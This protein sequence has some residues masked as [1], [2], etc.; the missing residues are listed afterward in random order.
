[1]DEARSCGFNP[2]TMH[3]FGRR[4]HERLEAAREEF[5]TLLGCESREISFT[6]GGT[7]SDNVAVLGFARANL[8]RR[9]LLILSA[10]EH[11]AC[12]QA[13]GRAAQEGAEVRLVAVDGSGTVRLDSLSE[14]LSDAG[15]RP[16][17]V[18]IMW[19][20]NEVGTV[21]PMVEIARL[22]HQ[23]DALLH[24]DAVQA[25]GKAEVSI[26]KLP[27][28]LLTATAHKLGGPVGIGLLYCRQGVDLEPLTFGGNQ[29]GGLW[30]GTQNPVAAVGFARAARLAVEGR[31]SATSRWLQ[32]RLALEGALRDG[33]PEL[34]VH[35]E[36]A[37]E[38]LPHLLSVGVPECDGGTL[39]LTLDLE[40]IA[41]S[42]GSACSSGA[43]KGSH[44][45]EAMDVVRSDEY[46]T[47]RFSF[48]PETSERDVERAGLAMIRATSSLA[49]RG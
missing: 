26:D 13:A 10:I 9:P 17:L 8:D 25:F 36:D 48:G 20:N 37:P 22:A 6:G 31:E 49:A 34:V 41:V 39:L 12:L 18:S 47:V 33:I 30:P 45:L 23:H 1:M 29:E 24:T 15:G 7:Q 19:A 28:D 40:G 4:A 42:G 44:V 38:R 21:Q 3:S 32:M 46:A 35:A 5:S 43:T 27:A 14:A 16:T 11:K 2:A